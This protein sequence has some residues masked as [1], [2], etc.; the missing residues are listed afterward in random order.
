MRI[1]S[2][3]QHTRGRKRPAWAR[4]LRTD[5]QTSVNSQEQWKRFWKKRLRA[6]RIV[7]PSSSLIALLDVSEVV[8]LAIVVTVAV[9]DTV[10]HLN[11]SLY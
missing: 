9:T 7:K 4:K 1:G 8:G 5:P 3:K 10:C 11:D 6:I 2:G